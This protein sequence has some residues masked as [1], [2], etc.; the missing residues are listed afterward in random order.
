MRRSHARLWLV[1]ANDGYR[2]G[3]E[4]WNTT[5]EASNAE[6]ARLMVTNLLMAFKRAF[7]SVEAH[8]IKERDNG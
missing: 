8:E 4:R 1:F 7:T 5:I 6:N 2:R 3:A